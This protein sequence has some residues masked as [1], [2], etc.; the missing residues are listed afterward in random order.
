M[1]YDHKLTFTIGNH[2]NIF[3][4]DE[5]YV[6]LTNLVIFIS[7]TVYRVVS[8]TN[9]RSNQHSVR[10]HAPIQKN[11]SFKWGPIRSSREQALG[12]L[13]FLFLLRVSKKNMKLNPCIYIVVNF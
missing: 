6:I 5:L 9:T 11:V 10:P 2:L 1:I 7:Y 4:Y 8:T 13:H 12:V 3:N